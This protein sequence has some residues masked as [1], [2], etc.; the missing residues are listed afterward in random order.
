[1]GH[2]PD[3][4]FI[5]S[6][7]REEANK[8]IDTFLASQLDECTRTR[9]QGLIRTG[10]VK[11]ND[12]IPKTSYRLSPGDSVELTIPAAR[13]WHLDPESIDLDLIYEDSSLIVLNKPPG[14]VTHPAPGHSTGTIVNGLLQHCRDLSGIGGILRPGIVHRLDKDTSGVLVIAKNDRIHENLTKQFESRIVTKKY[15][16][17][18][19]GLMTQ[20]KGEIDLPLGRHPKKRKE[21]AVLPA[22]GKESITHWQV[23]ESYQA[24]FSLLSISPKTGR[25]HQIRV[26]LSYLGHPIVGDRVYGYKKEWWKKHKPELAALS[27]LIERQM[28]HAETLGFIHP[29]TGRYCEF[30]AEMPLDLKAVIEEIRSVKNGPAGRKTLT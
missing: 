16:A 10:F 1:V 15:L 9:I 8:R 20:T 30:Q 22:K 28:L 26:H 21:M 18:V 19:H 24:G 14:I 4:H 29:D 25:T 6:I 2:V 13:P 11:V 5:F 23:V 17:V 3:K 27:M 7:T 12:A